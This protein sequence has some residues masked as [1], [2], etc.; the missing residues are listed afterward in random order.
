MQ[1][2]Y[3]LSDGVLTMDTFLE[4]EFG[5]VVLSTSASLDV[6]TIGQTSALPVSMEIRIQE[7]YHF[8]SILK[9]FDP[10]FNTRNNGLSQIVSPSPAE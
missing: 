4:D 8:L 7:M 2:I 9:L 3:N 10:Q 1:R 5:D 6:S